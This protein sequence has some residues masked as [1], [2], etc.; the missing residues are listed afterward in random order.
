M[1][2]GLAI[3]G[4]VQLGFAAEIRESKRNPASAATRWIQPNE[5]APLI[6]RAASLS[7][8]W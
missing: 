6:N 3:V 5:V 2:A 1:L 7:K 8:D 4:I